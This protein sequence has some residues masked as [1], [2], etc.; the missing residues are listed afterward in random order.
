[1]KILFLFTY[2]VSLKDWEESGLASREIKSF[3]KMN[4][5]YGI[6]YIFLTFGDFKDLNYEEKYPFVKIVPIFNFVKR[7]NGKIV[8]FLSTL[9]RIKKI[10]KQANLNFDL[11]KTNQLYGSWLAL[12]IKILYRKPLIIRTGYDLLT[13][14]LKDKKSLLKIILYYVLTLISLLFC[15]L[16]TVTS[17]IDKDFL[18]KLFPFAK[19]KIILRRN[20]V[21]ISSDVNNFDSRYDKKFI[22][23]GRLEK[24]KNFDYLIKKLDGSDIELDIYG[25]GSLKNK[26]VELNNKNVNFYGSIQNSVLLER[27]QKYK[28]FITS[29]LYEGNPK[30]IIEAMGSGCVVIAPD[31][32]SIKEIVI[33][34]ETGILYNPEI[35]N[36]KN[37]IQSQLEDTENMKRISNNAKKYAKK[38]HSLENYILDEVEEFNKVV[39]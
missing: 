34:E 30:A 20:W 19:S 3:K 36:L 5:K 24:Q 31:I 15:N 27:Y 10:I 28:V 7:K 8:N 2:G 11:I 6:E 23:V 22:S 1:M 16:Y 17:K 21:N 4:E 26:L 37:V 25:E 29:T 39:S 32:E 14:S 35:H 13:F 12:T 33:H 18:V 38:N 9:I